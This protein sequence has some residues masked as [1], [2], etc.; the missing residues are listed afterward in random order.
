MLRTF[1]RQSIEVHRS[2]VTCTR[3]YRIFFGDG[4]GFISVLSKYGSH[5]ARVT[6]A[7]FKMWPVG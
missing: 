3:S 6:V 2:L 1:Y 7:S 4:N 5:Q